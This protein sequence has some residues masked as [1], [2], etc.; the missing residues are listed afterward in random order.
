MKFVYFSGVLQFNFFLKIFCPMLKFDFSS[1]YIKI[2]LFYKDPQ[3]NLYFM[4]RQAGSGGSNQTS[5]D[6][7]FK[8]NYYTAKTDLTFSIKNCESFWFFESAF[9]SRKLGPAP[10]ANN[11][12][13]FC[14]VEICFHKDVQNLKKVE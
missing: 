6:F 14:V 4:P 13:D 10:Y 3:I 5:A 7:F 2:I 1:I 12:S 11:L 8:C 9:T